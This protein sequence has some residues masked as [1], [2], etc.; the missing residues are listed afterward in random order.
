MKLIFLGP[1]GAGKGT[2]AQQLM[3]ELT[4]LRFLPAIFCAK[5]SV[6]KRPPALSPRD[7][8]TAVNWFLMKW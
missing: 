6:K 7:I 5:R 8:S 4:S 3:T 2:Q 1:P